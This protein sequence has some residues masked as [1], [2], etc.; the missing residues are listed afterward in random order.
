MFKGQMVSS[1][2]KSP[3]CVPRMANDFVSS[4]LSL[5]CNLLDQD[6]AI[7]LT[8]HMCM[9]FYNRKLTGVK[10]DKA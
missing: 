1:R 9:W 6:L 10:L 4:Y 7:E 2:T 5:K 3:E 8:Y